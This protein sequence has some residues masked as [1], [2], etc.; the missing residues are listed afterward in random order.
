L[1]I[2]H[3]AQSLAATASSAAL[4][5]ERL[6]VVDHR[7]AGLERRAHHARVAGIHGHREVAQRLDHGEDA[8]QLLGLVDGR[9]ARPAR[10]AADIDQVHALV[11]H[12]AR[13]GRT[14]AAE[15]PQP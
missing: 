9:R 8:A 12:L 5:L 10:L 13:L 15:R 2:R 1:C 11:D 7:G 4:R 3:T 14:F 6:D